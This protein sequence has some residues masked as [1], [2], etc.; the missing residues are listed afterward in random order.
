MGSEQASEMSRW[1]VAVL[2]VQGGDVTEVRGWGQAGDLL[3]S[4]N[5]EDI[6]GKPIREVRRLMQGPGGTRRTGT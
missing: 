1:E 6:S 4:V 2:H 5:G 3:L